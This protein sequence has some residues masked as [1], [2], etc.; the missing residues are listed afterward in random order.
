M[1]PRRMLAAAIAGACCV[2]VGAVLMVSAERSA[3]P[4][5]PVSGGPR[6]MLVLHPANVTARQGDAVTWGW[7]G[8][9]RQRTTDT[10]GLGDSKTRSLHASVAA[11]M[12]LCDGPTARRGV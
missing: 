4:P 12:R 10:A 6:G 11:V 3:S 2:A 8:S 9:S 5:V 1:G 7:W